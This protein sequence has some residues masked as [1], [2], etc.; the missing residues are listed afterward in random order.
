MIDINL[1]E[2]AQYDTITLLAFIS[3]CILKTLIPLLSIYWIK[4]DPYKDLN[5]LQLGT[6]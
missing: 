4:I 2:I 1:E 3:L 6:Q 5:E